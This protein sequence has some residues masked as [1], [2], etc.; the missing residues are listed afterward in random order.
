MN[1]FEKKLLSYIKY[2]EN[3]HIKYQKDEYMINLSGAKNMKYMEIYFP[4]KIDKLLFLKSHI[5]HISKCELIEKFIIVCT[6][7]HDFYG[8]IINIY[9][10]VGNN[11][12]FKEDFKIKLMAYYY[13]Q[14][15]KYIQEIFM[16][17]YKHQPKIYLK[18]HYKDLSDPTE[19][20]IC[21]H[22][23]SHKTLMSW[24]DKNIDSCLAFYQKY[25]IVIRITEILFESKI[26]NK[27]AEDIEDME[28]FHSHPCV[29]SGY[30]SNFIDLLSKPQNIDKICKFIADKYKS[31]IISDEI[32]SKLGV[33]KFKKKFECCSDFSILRVQYSK[34]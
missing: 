27:T 21:K 29:Y 15:N 34:Y 18:F 33:S 31:M 14:F 9:K 4:I 19:K 24:I 32:M 3:L 17:L 1:P 25:N 22:Q 23:L 20:F 28:H 11:G 10:R 2:E 30:I 6:H 16:K 7:T 12:T 8:K 26:W 13:H 5:K